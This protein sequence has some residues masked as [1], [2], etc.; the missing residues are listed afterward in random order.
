MN[1]RDGKAMLERGWEEIIKGRV[2]EERNYFI[3]HV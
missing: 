3:C 1:K 2:K